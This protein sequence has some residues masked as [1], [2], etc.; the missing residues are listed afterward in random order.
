MVAAGIAVGAVGMTAAQHDE[1]HKAVRQLSVREIVEKLDGKESSATAV[2]VTYEPGE[3]GKSGCAAC[4][5]GVPLG[6]GERFYGC[7]T[8]RIL[9]AAGAHE[10]RKTS[11]FSWRRKKA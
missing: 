7:P 6:S 11:R 8:P 5:H 9:L 3:A 4:N 2:E 10:V 1:E